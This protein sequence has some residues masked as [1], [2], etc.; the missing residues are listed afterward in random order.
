[1][2]LPDDTF[3]SSLPVT[4]WHEDGRRT[5]G[6]ER[7]FGR[8]MGQGQ[9]GLQWWGGP[10]RSPKKCVPDDHGQREPAM[11]QGRATTARRS[12][13]LLM[14]MFLT[15]SLFPPGLGSSLPVE[16]CV[17][18]AYHGVG[19][20]QPRVMAVLRRAVLS[21]AFAILRTHHDSEAGAT[22]TVGPGAQK[23]ASHSP[24]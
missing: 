18:A 8:D 2:A 4:R 13:R 24:S 7:K 17:L 10:Q 9:D 19:V 11:K 23:T 22:P 14:P 16:R 12:L 3:C 1:M 21:P 20:P 5:S 15:P 6:C